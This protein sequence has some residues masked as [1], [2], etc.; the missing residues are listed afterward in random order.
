MCISKF[1]CAWLAAA[2]VGFVML[3]LSAPCFAAAQENPEVTTLLNQA[4]DEAAVLSRD[5][6]EMEALTRTAASWE[7][8]ADT[9]HRIKEDVNK[10]AKTTE[11]LVSARGSASPWQRQ[12]IDRMVPLMRDLASNTTAAIN[13]LN[14]NRLRPTTPDYTEYLKDNDE[15]AHQLADTLSN[16]VQYGQTR[17]KM[18]KLEQRLEVA[19]R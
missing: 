12:A 5:A 9:L 14:Q 8:H 6:D 4:R 16:F 15:T 17:A 7:T 19:R 11:K 13:H 2:L 10:L 3:P 1:V 18:E